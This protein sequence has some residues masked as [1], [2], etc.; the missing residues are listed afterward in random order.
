MSED[1]EVRHPIGDNKTTEWEDRVLLKR[2]PSDTSWFRTLKEG[3][4]YYRKGASGAIVEETR[5]QIPRQSPFFKRAEER[6]QQRKER[7]Q[8]G[9]LAA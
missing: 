8:E 3:G 2:D 5:V 9:D 6:G 7:G 4:D 1:G